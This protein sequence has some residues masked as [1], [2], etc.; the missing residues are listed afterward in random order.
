MTVRRH[1]LLSVPTP[2]IPVMY[3]LGL[4]GQP[5]EC[6]TATKDLSSERLQAIF[7]KSVKV[8]LPK[9]THLPFTFADG[10]VTCC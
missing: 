4:N 1:K 6:L 5:L 8:S 7:E 10:S 2:V 9:L 3:I